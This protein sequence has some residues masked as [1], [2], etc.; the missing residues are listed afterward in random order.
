MTESALD[1]VRIIL[2]EP[3]GALN[4][5]SIARIMKNMG[6]YHLILVNPQ[7]DPRSAE[8]RQM[9]VHADD[10]LAAAQITKTLPDALRGCHRAIATTVRTRSLDMP[11]EHPRDALPWLLEDFQTDGQTALIFG[12]EE[13][14]L[15][16]EELNFAQ[17]SVYIPSSPIYPSLNLAQAV[18]I[19]CYELSQALDSERSEVRSFAP[20]TRTLEPAPLDAIEAYCQHLERLL[21][22]IGYL[23][24]HTANSRMEKFRRL[25]NRAY[26]S[27]PEVALL[28][29]ILRQGEWALNQKDE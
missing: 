4:V 19:C 14:G 25:L 17:R 22:K 27:A 18:A 21:L 26:P 8:A 24:P 3:A 5:G 9:A 29:G 16:N 20:D 11:L 28:R 10:V 1:R 13:R 23:H 2:V 12:A 6:L 15:S 7:C